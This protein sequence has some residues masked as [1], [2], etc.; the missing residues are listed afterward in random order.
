MDSDINW[1]AIKKYV[2]I[3]GIVVLFFVFLALKPWVTIGAGQR[4]VVMKFGNV[5]KEVYGEGLHFFVPIQTS[6]KVLSVRTQATKFDE[7]GADSAGTKDSQRVD[8]SVTVNWHLDPA[9]VNTVYQTIGDNDMVVANVLDNNTK[10]AVKQSVSKFEALEV[11][12]NRDQVAAEALAELQARV[13]P[14]H[15]IVEN[16]SLT[17][18]NFSDEFNKAVEQAQTAQQEALRAQ[19]QVQQVKNEADAAI[20]KAQGEANALKQVQQSL[21]PELLQKMAIEKWNGAFPQYWLGTGVLPF[22]NLSGK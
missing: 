19:Y 15:V 2:K 7:K 9:H 1:K 13:S 20:A 3:A 5:Q 11:Q 21:T 12:K 22:I 10:Q 18:I 8:V 6:V 14:Y 16:L 4:G 17:N